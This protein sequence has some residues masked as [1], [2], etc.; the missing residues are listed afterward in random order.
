[1]KHPTN[2]NSVSKR[3]PTAGTPLTAHSDP[4]RHLLRTQAIELRNSFL[5]A[6]KLGKP[7]NTFVT[8]D[9]VGAKGW[10]TDLPSRDQAG[11]IAESFRK[12]IKDWCARHGL[13]PAFIYVLEN[14]PSGGPGI[15]MHLLMH[16]PEGPE[17][18]SLRN[19]L[20]RCLQMAGG[21]SFSTSSSAPVAGAAL[22]KSRRTPLELGGSPLSVADQL[23]KLRYLSKGISPR[24]VVVVDG[25]RKT[26]N[27]LAG[28]SIDPHVTLRPQG[29]V[30]TTKRAGG[31]SSLGKTSRRKAGW[32]EQNDLL[33]L[34]RKLERDALRKE[35]ENKLKAWHKKKGT[36]P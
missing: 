17:W 19:S 32:V 12:A 13:T 10:S 15:H 8:V 16:L 33:W 29:D 11:K 20:E 23:I 3:G 7:L 28:D 34:S 18:L 27:Q 9:L 14:P 36:T 30:F 25:V 22:P 24:E 35:T 2:D 4:S 21:W 26:L 1:M 5:F 31:T 6:Q